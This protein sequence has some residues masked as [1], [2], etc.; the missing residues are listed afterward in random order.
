MGKFK[1]K[2]VTVKNISKDEFGMPTINGKKACTFRIKREKNVKED[3]IP[4]G[5]GDKIDPNTLDK[6][7]LKVGI[8]VEMEHTDDKKK[9]MSIAI[10]HLSE[11]SEYYTKL[12]NSG[13]VDE[14]PAL[15]LAKHLGI[16]GRNEMNLKEI[17]SQQLKKMIKLANKSGA[18]GY[19]IIKSLANDLGW[20]T[21]K[22]ASE[23][24]KYNLIHLTESTEDKL[25][26]IIQEEIKKVLNEYSYIVKWTDRNYRQFSKK[27]KDDPQG[28]PE[29]GLVK[30]KKFM[31]KLEDKDAKDKYGLFRSIS[32]DYVD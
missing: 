26:K 21:D 24:E 9:A 27:F 28:A 4:G 11:D 15:E 31:R 1:N 12:I 17:N 32:L 8:A 30:A 18:K 2:P 19:D 7:Q 22:V 25:K 6:N 16:I 20:S 13:L 23:L 10:D 5:K 3:L 29:N 14:T